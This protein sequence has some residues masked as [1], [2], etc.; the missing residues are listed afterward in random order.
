MVGCA[1]SVAGKDCYAMKLATIRT[2]DGTRAVRF[3]D[4]V[5]VETGHS[6]VR[7]AL[8]S[9]NWRTRLPLAAGPQHR[10]VSLQYAP[11]VPVPEK[12]FC[13]GLNYLD[14]IVETG[15]DQPQFPDLFTKFALTLIGAQDDIALPKV[16]DKVDFEAELT[17]VIGDSVRDANEQAAEAA[18]AGY[19]IM[20]DV[21][22]RDYQRRTANVT[23]GKIFEGSS[24]VGPVLVTPDEL[25]SGGLAI[26]TTVNGQLM[27]S[28]TTD[29]LV[30]GAVMLVSYISRIITLNPGDLIATGTPGGVGSKR[31]PPRWL[32]DGDE[33]VTSIDGIGSLR[34]RCTLSR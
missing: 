11:L 34:N 26:S 4:Q 18:I 33:V 28:S 22:V 25:P 7:E 27:Q 30:F 24:P 19:T 13:V 17:V 20:N 23:Q 9:P 21:S 10:L 5:A 3:E 6:D 12:I 32:A 16:S 15:L 29:Q 14:H 31:T 2:S 8:E 1:A